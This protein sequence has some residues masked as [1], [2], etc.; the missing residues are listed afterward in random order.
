MNWF[1]QVLATINREYDRRI[2]SASEITV[3]HTPAPAVEP[4][5]TTSHVSTTNDDAS[6]IQNVTPGT[7]LSRSHTEPEKSA[8]PPEPPAPDL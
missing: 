5:S 4:P 6:E 8:S 7:R 1:Q 3:Y 2:R